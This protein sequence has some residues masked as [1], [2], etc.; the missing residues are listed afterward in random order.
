MGDPD[1][2]ISSVRVH[3]GRVSWG[4]MSWDLLLDWLSGNTAPGFVAWL[5]VWQ[6]CTGPGERKF[7]FIVLWLTTEQVTLWDTP[8]GMWWRTESGRFI[9]V[10]D[11]FRIPLKPL[12]SKTNGTILFLWILSH[13]W[14]NKHKNCTNFKHILKQWFPNW[15]PHSAWGARDENRG[16]AGGGTTSWDKNII[17]YGIQLKWLKGKK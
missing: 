8:G 16:G 10:I 17:L 6:H 14:H 9:T 2:L 4:E 13:Y 7:G 5:A 1:G 3:I 11:M 12:A 15:G